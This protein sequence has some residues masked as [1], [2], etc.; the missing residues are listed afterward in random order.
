MTKFDSRDERPMALTNLGVTILA[1]ENGKYALVSCDGYHNVEPIQGI[2]PHVTNR[3][4]TIETLPWESGFTSESQV[5]DGALVASML[6]DFTGERDLFL[7]V[8]GRLH[9]PKFEFA[10]GLN[11]GTT[12]NLSVSGVQIEVD[13]GYEGDRL[14]L[15]E[16][17]M[18]R[19]DN[20]ITR[21]LYYPC[22]M[23]RERGVKK[24][25]V[26]IFLTY[27]NK[28]F[29]FRQYRFTNSNAYDSIILERARDY[30]LG[31]AATTPTIGHALDVVPV[32]LL[33][34]RVPFPQADSLHTVIDL[35]DAVANGL[36]DKD[37]LAEFIGFN[38]RQSDYYGNAARFLGLLDRSHRGF[39]VNA[40]SRQ[41]VGK[42]HAGRVGDIT[43]RLCGLPVFRQALQGIASGN[44]LTLEQIADLIRT[45]T[46]L[47]GTTAGRRAQTVAAWVG[48][49]ESLAGQ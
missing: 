29:S 35:A 38:P 15:I 46:Q 28:V 23:W 6:C 40:E 5:L 32:G 49:V 25:I 30:V 2:T 14:Y 3:M 8:R 1:V 24:E 16:T 34:S 39:S 45:H 47:T 37:A 19:R 18:G 44:P 9:S 41:F 11:D 36:D 31:P 48:W 33:P 22:R 10:I 26:P 13:G 12:R 4:G 43:F 42:T 17:K 7:T 21:Q 20:F 27:S